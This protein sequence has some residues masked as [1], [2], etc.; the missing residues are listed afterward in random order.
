MANKANVTFK[1]KPDTC[2]ICKGW[3]IKCET[4][5]TV[6]SGDSIISIKNVPA[7]VCGNCGEAYFDPKIS[8]K[9]DMV[10]D[11]FYK[12]ELLTHPL[13]A[14]EVEFNRVKCNKAP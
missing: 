11:N 14:G 10:M 9:I 1:G 6:K 7:F 2:A 8:R 5:F 13:P 4:E 3:L 12:G